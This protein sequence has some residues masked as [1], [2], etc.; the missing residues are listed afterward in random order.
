MIFLFFSSF[1]IFHSRKMALKCFILAAIAIRFAHGD[2]SS[3]VYDS[4]AKFPS[5]EKNWTVIYTYELDEIVDE[6]TEFKRCM[7]KFTDLCQSSNTTKLCGTFCGF[8][9]K[10]IRWIEARLNY[11]KLYDVIGSKPFSNGRKNAFKMQTIGETTYINGELPTTFAQ[12]L[13]LNQKIG[14]LNKCRKCNLNVDEYRHIISS[15]SIIQL[16]KVNEI[17]T[18]L[19]YL[20][21][22]KCDR[23]FIPIA[24][25]RLFSYLIA[26]EQIIHGQ[27]LYEIDVTKIKSMAMNMFEASVVNNTFRVN[28]SIPIK[29]KDC[30]R[31]T[32]ASTSIF[33]GVH[34]SGKMQFNN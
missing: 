9:D 2:S 27:S 21:V 14:V 26:V 15:I 10:E 5:E 17:E 31:Q 1:F 13:K 19:E 12:I 8:I 4:P 32:T 25:Q 16:G 33:V 30:L 29:L 11:I 6:L 18:A 7:A 3:F 34:S 24:L 23:T 22:N 20:R 28:I